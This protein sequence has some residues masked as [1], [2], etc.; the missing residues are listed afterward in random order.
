MCHALAPALLCLVALVPGGR[1][2]EARPLGINLAQVAY[3]STEQPFLNI[4]KSGG[5]DNYSGWATATTSGAHDTG[6]EAYLQ[7][8][9]NGY[10]T[11]LVASR[12]L[13]GRQKFNMVR[14]LIN[15]G[16]GTPPGASGPYPS[17]TYRLKFIGKGTVR[18]EGDAISAR[19]DT[20][21]S[22]NALTNSRA[23]TYVSCTFTVRAST[24]GIWLD[25]T[26]V[27]SSSDNPRDISVVQEKYAAS[28][29][30][31]AIFNP[32]FLAM[33]KG[34]S[35]LRF[36]DWER[37]NDEFHALFA[38]GA[39]SPGATSL[40]L[41]K[42]WEGPSGSYPVI[43]IDGERREASFTAGASAV[44]WSGGLSNA[45]GASGKWV[46][47][48]QTYYGS[49]YIVQ[50]TWTGRSLPANAFWGL[51]D[52]V[53]L[54]VEVALCNQIGANCHLNVPLLYSDADIKD[55]GM[56]VMSGAGMQSGYRPLAANLTATFE[57]SNEVWNSG[58]I[59]Y[60]VAGSLGGITWPTQRSGGGNYAWNRN[61]F[62]MRTAQMADNLK[63]ALGPA[64]FER[65]LPVLG[66]QAAGTNSA[67]EAL[68]TAYWNAGPA[69]KHAI[70]QVA[71]ASYWGATP[72]VADC[73]TMTAQSDGGLADFFATLRSQT[74]ASG[75]I[76]TSVPNGGWLG[77]MQD[78]VSA[79]VKVMAR[80]PS[81]TLI[82]YE[83]GQGFQA[84]KTNTCPGWPDLVAR[85]ERDSRMEGAVTAAL[86]FWATEVGD[87][88]AHINNL[89]DDVSPIAWFGAFG[90]LESL[91]QP[92]SPLAVAPPKYRALVRYIGDER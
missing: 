33:L 89:Y 60:D 73:A 5:A 19:G 63:A 25:I 72:S 66:A 92:I 11:S 21:P 24:T 29:D 39:I 74:G 34:F 64:V 53:P 8:D 9:S 36:M 88:Q 45:S 27:S 75:A 55:M 17:G 23:N 56:L 42:P 26:A 79:Y 35:S 18:L 83:G 77:E 71:I 4:M 12:A 31:G 59:Q 15:Y 84:T 82:A 69:T 44:N 22:D 68:T 40:T 38:A 6:E 41:S 90:H 7:V 2:A 13:P 30:A 28:Y 57:L 65:V 51:A 1:P 16:Q 70:K 50:K 52:G 10:P 14:T 80:Y 54:E 20:C 58:F 48:S 78:W 46:F 47:G 76:Y 87:S 32:A 43:F 81:L 91:M 85:A 49:L 62:G 3:Y 61:W 67:T 86:D 37:T